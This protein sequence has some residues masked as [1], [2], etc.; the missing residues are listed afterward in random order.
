MRFVIA[1]IFGCGAG[2][3]IGWQDAQTHKQIIVERL[4]Q[5]TGGATRGKVGFN[6]DSVMKNAEQTAPAPR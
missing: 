2:Y 6:P 3:F 5:R 4:V 1:L